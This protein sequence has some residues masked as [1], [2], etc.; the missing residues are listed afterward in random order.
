MS[1]PTAHVRKTRSASSVPKSL[2]Y[3]CSKGSVRA[4]FSVNRLT[5]SCTLYSFRP[6]I[7]LYGL[8]YAPRIC[9]RHALPHIRRHVRLLPRQRAR[10]DTHVL[11]R[12][13]AWRGEQRV[14]RRERRSPRRVDEAVVQ[15]DVHVSA[16]EVLEAVVGRKRA[17]QCQEGLE[18]AFIRALEPKRDEAGE[19]GEANQPK[20]FCSTRSECDTGTHGARE[21]T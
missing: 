16:L 11:Q 12:S 18:G 13:E 3:Y 21:V 7:I 1:S 15:V 17:Q 14:E 20:Q 8:E 4:P 9:A 5:T 2:S 10:G 6:R 19:V